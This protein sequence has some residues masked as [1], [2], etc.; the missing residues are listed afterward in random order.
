MS[1]TPERLQEVDFSEPYMNSQQRLVVREED[2]DKYTS[3]EQFEDVPV[4]VQKQTTQEELANDEL[5]DAQVTSLQ[6]KF[7]ML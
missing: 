6:K 1:P 7:Q 3:G 4:S 5:K 2:Q